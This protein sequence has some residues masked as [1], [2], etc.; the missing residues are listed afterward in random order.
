VKTT[1]EIVKICSVCKQ[2]FDPNQIPG[3]PA[4]EAGAFMAKEMWQ[5]A[6][7]LCPACLAARGVL[8]MMYC[9]EMG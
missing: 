2:E 7:D 9:R 8:G 3:T 4:E 1:G 6:G 5:D